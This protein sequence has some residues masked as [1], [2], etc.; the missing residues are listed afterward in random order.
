MNTSVNKILEHKGGKGT[1]ARVTRP[2]YTDHI[3]R[4]CL[5]QIARPRRHRA[6]IPRQIPPRLGIGFVETRVSTRNVTSNPRTRVMPE[7]RQYVRF[8]YKN[9]EAARNMAPAMSGR[10]IVAIVRG[11]VIYQ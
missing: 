1:L 4:S 3:P 5:R 11:V 10:K 7:S 9:R 2:K 8:R 6:G